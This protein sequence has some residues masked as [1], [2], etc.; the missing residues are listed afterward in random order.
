M[1][2]RRRLGGGACRFIVAHHSEALGHAPQGP[3]GLSGQPTFS[4]EHITRRRSYSRVDDAGVLLRTH[5]FFFPP[6]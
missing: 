5:V 2:Q 4:P 3:P 1:A 6:G